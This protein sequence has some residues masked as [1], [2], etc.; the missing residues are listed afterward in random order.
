MLELARLK[1]GRPQKGVL[2]G[3]DNGDYDDEDMDDEEGEEEQN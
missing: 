3:M 1:R 2:T